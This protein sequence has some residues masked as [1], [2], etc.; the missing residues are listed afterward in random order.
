MRRGYEIL[1]RTC[2]M[3]VV[4]GVVA[5]LAGC[6]ERRFVVDTNVPGSQ[7]TINNIPAGPSPAD[8]RWD[9]P[10]YYEFRVVARGYEPK[11]ERVRVRAKWYE[12]P[13]IDFFFE[14]LYPFHIEDVRRIPI[15]LDPAEPVMTNQLLETANALRRRADELPPPERPD[16]PQK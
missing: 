8:A 9:Y 13:G 6:V 5:G 1:P 11:V 3:I 2:A 10:G 15:T 16:P 14:V 4:V 12:Y 7:V